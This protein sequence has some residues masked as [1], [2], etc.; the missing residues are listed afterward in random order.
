MRFKRLD[1]NLLVVLDAL[2]RERSVTRAARELNLSQPAMSAA[3]ARLREYFNDDILV[4]QGKRMLPTAH[5]QYLAPLVAQ[6]LAD[7]EMRILGAAVFDPATSQRTFRLCASDYATVVLLHPL[8]A[9]LEKSAPGIRIE[10]C[11]PTPD[12]LV[13]LEHGE[14]DFLLTPEQFAAHGHPRHLLFEEQHVV[15]GC[16]RNP[17]FKRTL[18]EEVFFAQGQVIMGVGP[19]QSFA[20]R[21]LGELNARRRIDVVCASFLAVPWLLPGT[22][23]IAMMHKRLAQLMVKKLPLSIAPLPFAF[24]QMR[25]IVQYHTARAQDYGMQWLLQALLQQAQQLDTTIDS[26]D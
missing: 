26:M 6:A 8:L 10:I 4:P 9:A 13:Q 24:P 14:I 1:L 18:T 12:A 20:E 21:E 25:E 11:A 17:V 16:R 15:V 19:G 23:R 2:L 7:I 5:A 22:E 3:L